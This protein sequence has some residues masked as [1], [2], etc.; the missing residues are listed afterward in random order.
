MK[1]GI[2]FAI[3]AQL[4]TAAAYKYPRTNN[5]AILN[6]SNRL[7]YGNIQSVQLRRFI[8]RSYLQCATGF[9][10]SRTDPVCRKVSFLLS[11]LTM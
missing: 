1:I 10:N 4:A 2:V 5:I 7:L 3:I 6:N 11:H 8:T 9:R